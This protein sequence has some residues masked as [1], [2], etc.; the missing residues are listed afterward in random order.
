[1]KIQ[2]YELKMLSAPLKTPFKTALRNVFTL[3]ALILT[4]HTNTGYIGYGSASPTAA[5]TGETLPSITCA[6]ED[7]ILPSLMNSDLSVDSLAKIKRSIAHNPSAKSAAEIAVYDLL[8]KEKALPLYAYLGGKSFCLNSD[9][10]ISLDSPDKMLL[11]SVKAVRGGHKYLKLKLGGSASEDISRIDAVA[12]SCSAILRLDANQAWDFE[13]AKAVSD[14]CIA[15]GYKV[16]LIEQPFPAGRFDLMSR[17]KAE[18][19][20]PLLADES[21]F[22]LSDAKRVIAENA[23]DYINIKLAKTGGISEAMKLCEIAESAGMQCMMGC[24]LESPIGIVAAAHVACS[25][26]AITMCDLDGVELLKENPVVSDT[27]FETG[28]IKPGKLPGLGITDIKFN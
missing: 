8:A 11:D 24:M 12:N 21:V 5:V 4:L 7:Y 10:T 28:K 6:L 9:I 25:S 27:V 17:F 14:H 23:A 2:S 26:P 13:T 20:I 22:S 15:R 18:S 1:M 3:E 19:L 16:E